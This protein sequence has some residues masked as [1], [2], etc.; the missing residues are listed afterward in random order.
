[1]DKFII[2]QRNSEFCPICKAKGVV[3]YFDPIQE[4][5]TDNITCR[6]CGHTFDCHYD[7]RI[8]LELEDEDGKIY[9]MD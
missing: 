8:I 9:F 6:I 3:S 4:Y 7:D 2:S 5:V 1:M